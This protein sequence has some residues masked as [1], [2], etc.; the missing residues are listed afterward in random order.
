MFSIED[1][2]NG[3]QNEAKEI[4]YE[5][6]ITLPKEIGAA[7]EQGDLS[8]NAEYE[9]AKERQS[10]LMG[11][12]AQIQQRID[13]LASIDMT[14]IPRDRVSIGS[15]VYV[16]ELIS[17]ESKRFII[18]PHEAMDGKPEHISARSPIARNLIGSYPGDEV[19]VQ[20]PK[21]E[22]EYRVDK[23]ITY[24]GEVIE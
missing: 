6:K 12:L 3:L 8:E 5:L 9:S 17:L 13:D 7:I 1:I 15:T 21:G 24:F 10:T 18:V 20:I 22:L 4:D 2:I 23:I 19:F 14:T 11:R 16:T